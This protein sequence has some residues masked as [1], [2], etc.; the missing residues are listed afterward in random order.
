[1]LQMIRPT[2]PI[3]YNHTC[4]S[5]GTINNSRMAA[6]VLPYYRR[7]NNKCVALK[8]ILHICKR[9]LS[10]TTDGGENASTTEHELYIHHM[11]VY[12]IV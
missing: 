5:T 7:Y 11:T 12:V 6:V 4:F 8:L 1:M 9:S 2:L 10:S 3:S